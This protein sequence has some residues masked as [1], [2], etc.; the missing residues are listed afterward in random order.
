MSPTINGITNAIISEVLQVT[1]HWPMSLRKR[2]YRAHISLS[3]SSFCVGRGVHGDFSRLGLRTSLAFSVVLYAAIADSL[4]DD[5][6]IGTCMGFPFRET[7]QNA[8]ENG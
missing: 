1:N 7:K 4:R 5:V 6:S 2:V 8:E 3:D